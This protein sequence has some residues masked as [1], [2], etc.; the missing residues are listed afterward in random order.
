MLFALAL[1]LLLPFALQAM[2]AGS[3]CAKC[4]GRNKFNASTKSM[5][6]AAY[7]AAGIAQKHIC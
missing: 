5:C 3:D 4:N 2:T 7:Q 1:N 6:V